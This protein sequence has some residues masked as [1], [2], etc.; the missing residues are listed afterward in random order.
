MESRYLAEMQSRR[1]ARRRLLRAGGAFSLGA[2]SLAVL[3]CSD[4]DG[5]SGVGTN[6][7]PTQASTSPTQA[8]TSPTQAS[9]SPTGSSLYTSAT[10]EPRY[11]GTYADIAG[12]TNNHSVIDNA[13]N[14][15]NIYGVTAYDRPLTG[16]RDERRFQ[17][18]AAESLELAETTRLVMK[19]RPGMV[20]HDKAPVNGRNVRA[21][22]IKATQ[23]Y[24][25]SNPTS[26]NVTFQDGFLD[27]VEIPDERTVIYHLSN[28][29][30]YLFTGLSLGSPHSQSIIPEE[31]LPDIRDKPAIG[32]GPFEVTDAQHNVAYDFKKFAQYRDADK[33][34]FDTRKVLHMTDDVT[35]E[36]A[37]RSGQLH[38]WVVPG[39]IQERILSE[40][41]PDQFAHANFNALDYNG[42]NAMTNP[43]KGF[44]PWQDVRVRE[45]MYRLLDRQQIIDL[46]FRGNAEPT[47]GILP[48]GL[49]PEYL[50]DAKDTA[51]FFRKDIAE[52]KKLL[53]AANYD[54]SQTYDV[55]T[56]NATS[57]S[58]AEI[59]QQQWGQGG[60]KIRP[61]RREFAGFLQDVRNGEYNMY[62]GGSTG[63]D[64]PIRAIRY[65]HSNTGFA[66]SNFGMY[67]PEIDA[68][69][70]QSET[71]IDYEK[72]VALVKEIQMKCLEG[73]TVSMPLLTE[74]SLLAYDARLQNLELDVAYGQTYEVGAWFSA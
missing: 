20:Y 71:E 36:S 3:G 21:A 18:E 12:D 30:A 2:I 28:P 6:A 63:V 15:A 8:S 66:F 37:F 35:K 16:K 61:I 40:L 43:E 51:D 72:H 13:Q 14:G 7:S 1:V 25:T 65:Q 29:S 73:Y 57:L 58:M 69:I 56:L 60:I 10:G 34:Y 38:Y 5:T 22:D 4:D 47:T 32:S 44:R 17:L 45:A 62:V 68:L 64:A 55:W 54:E 42:I 41:D 48:G 33:V 74:N 70:E 27:A 67:D 50:L 53:S 59:L 46:A 11:G 49:P 19:L 52:A 9:T 23:E 39:P 31:T 26:Y 24:I